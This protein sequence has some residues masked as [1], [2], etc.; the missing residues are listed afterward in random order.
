MTS[1]AY[2]LPK[3]KN[4]ELTL[5]AECLVTAAEHADQDKKVLIIDLITKLIGGSKATFDTD[6]VP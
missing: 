3:L 2:W 1:V 5:L 4:G 6:K